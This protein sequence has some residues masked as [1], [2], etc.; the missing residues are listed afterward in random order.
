M[1]LNCI[2][3]LFKI[4]GK[5]ILTIFVTFWILDFLILQWQLWSRKIGLTLKN[6]DEQ[7]CFFLKN[8]ILTTF[9]EPNCGGTG[10]NE[11][12]G[13]APPDARDVV[14]PDRAAAWWWGV[15]ADTGIL[16]KC[17][18]GILILLT[19]LLQT[20]WLHREHLVPQVNRE[21]LVFLHRKQI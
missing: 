18:R 6:T 15:R 17:S 7:R 14:D 21:N 11:L 19:H 20:C 4:F 12:K 1:K 10:D 13:E 5:V 3:Y 16:D 9:S 8:K 2:S